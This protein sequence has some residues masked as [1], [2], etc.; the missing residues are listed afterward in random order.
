MASNLASGQLAT[1]DQRQLGDANL[2]Q[3]QRAQPQQAAL[4]HQDNGAVGQ[5]VSEMWERSRTATTPGGGSLVGAAETS[6]VCLAA[7][8]D[9]RGVDDESK[10]SLACRYGKPGLGYLRGHGN[11]L[12]SFDLMDTFPS[13]ADVFSFTLLERE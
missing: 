1:R 5:G 12:V 8:E 6:G 13:V 4:T 9:A 10:S 3:D 2:Q 7:Q 11:T